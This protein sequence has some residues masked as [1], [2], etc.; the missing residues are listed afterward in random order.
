M[1]AYL[2]WSLVGLA[3]IGMGAYVFFSKRAAPFSFWANAKT[4]PVADI[5]AYNRALGK[6]WTVY[7]AVFLLLGLPLLDG[8]DTPWILLSVIG[9][10]LEA[11]VAMAVYITVIERK[12]RKR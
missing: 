7:G 5:K 4:F 2:I 10:M 8:Q 1:E 6:L 3:F 9:T 11:I 12:Y